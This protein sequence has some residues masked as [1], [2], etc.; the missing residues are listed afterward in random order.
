M[1]DKFK[2]EKGI[3]KSNSNFKIL[4]NLNNLFKDKVPPA[5][6]LKRN[7]SNDELKKI[8]LSTKYYINNRDIINSMDM[9]KHSTL[10]QKLEKEDERQELLEEKR[11]K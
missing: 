4:T 2:Q 5:L 6:V 3:F 8:K 10:T 7:F 11:K 1:N 9:F